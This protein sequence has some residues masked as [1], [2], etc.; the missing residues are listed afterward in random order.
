MQID[1]DGLIS[2]LI[3][4]LFVGAAFFWKMLETPDPLAAAIGLVVELIRG[5]LL[6]I[7]LLFILVGLLF[8][9]G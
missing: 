4:L 5:G 6:G 9:F 7:G 2:I 3:G 1:R 8:I